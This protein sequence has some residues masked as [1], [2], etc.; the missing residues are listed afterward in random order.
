[1][2]AR[3]IARNLAIGIGL[4]ILLVAGL[5]WYGLSSETVAQRLIAKALTRAG[6]GITIGSVT[7]SIG[8]PLIVRDVS[9][10]QEAFAATIDSALLDWTPTGLIR[11]QIRI[12]RLHASGVHVTIPDS[13]PRDSAPKRPTLPMDVLLGD[14]LV[15]GLSVDAPN[16]IRIRGATARL[17]GRAEDYRF[18][19]AG[20][21]SLPR[22]EHVAARLR[23][24]GNLDHVELDSAGA[25][26][27]DGQLFA[28]GRVSWWPRTEWNLA[29]RGRNLEPGPLLEQP[30]R[31]PGAV[32]FVGVT[33]GH[34][35][36]IGPVGRLAIDT[37]GGAIRGQPLGGTAEV[38]FAGIAAEVPRADLRWGSARLTGRGAVADTVFADFDLVIGNLAT[39]LDDAGGSLRSS[40]TVRGTREAP[41][42]RA[43]FAGG[44]LKLGNAGAERA[45]GRAD[46][47]LSPRGRT[48]VRLDATGVTSGPIAFDSLTA[49]L[50]GRRDAHRLE[51][52]GSGPD[53]ALSVQADGGLRGSTWR[54]RLE[55]FIASTATYGEWALAAPTTVT[56]NAA[57]ATVA[58]SCILSPDHPGA[59]L[60]GSGAWLGGASWRAVAELERF[61]LA[62]LDA[63]VPDSV[64]GDSQ[65]LEGTLRASLAAES[66]GGRLEGR[67]LASAADAA[68]VYRRLAD[69]APR[70]IYFDSATALA[71]AGAGGATLDAGL[72]LLHDDS[73]A[74]A[75]LAADVSLPAFS[76]LGA[77]AGERLEGTVTG[78]MDSL[79][80]MTEFLPALDSLAGRASF[81]T[82]LAGTAGRP[83]FDGRLALDSIFV[84]L[85]RG[86]A[87]QGS[88][89]L[90]AA[91][92][93]VAPGQAAGRLTVVPRGVIYDYTLD[94]LPRR[95]FVDSGGIVA[96]V[97]GGGAGSWIEL[98][99]GISDSADSRIA[100]LSGR[101]DLPGYRA[102]GAPLGGEAMR[103]S[104][105]A[106][107]PDLAFARAVT[108]R[109][110]S[111]A[112]RVTL[113]A[114]GSGQVATPT[115]EAELRIEDFFARSETGT[116]T[117]GGL[118]GT[119]AAVVAPDS[120]L[121]GELKLVPSD[122]RFAYV[123]SGAFQ[124]ILL[125]TTALEVR[126]GADGIRG[127]LDLAIEDT[128][129]TTLGTFAGAFA[130]PGFR[131]I[132]RPI[133]P[134]PLEATLRAEVADLAF[135]EA[136]S[137][138]IDSLAGELDLDVAVGGT[139]G[140]PSWTGGLHLSN[141]AMRL[142]LLG[143]LYREIRF[144]A[145]GTDGGEVR[146]DGRAL[147]GEGEATL[148]GTTPLRPT[149]ERP[150][151]L[152]LNGRDFEA[153][154]TAQA[155]VVVT[156][157]LDMTL[158]GDTIELRGRVEVPRAHIQLTEIP[159][160]AVP[161]SDDVVFVGESLATPGTRPIRAEVEVVLG[162]SV[163]FSGFN[164]NADLSGALVLLESPLQPTRASGAVVIER[165]EYKAYGQDLTVT[166]G[167]VAFAGG[168]VDNPSLSIRASR[169]A[170][171]GTVAG[172]QI[173]G[174]LKTP[175]VTI[176]SE[177]AMS[178]N[179]ALHYI[180][181]GR[182][183]GEG[184]GADGSLLS[185]AASSL[186]L[187]G[188]NVLARSLGEGFGLDDARIESEEG[189][190]QASFV[191]GA[192][193]SP[194]LYVSYGIGLFDPIST[195][196]LRYLLSPKWTLQAE[197]GADTGADLLYRIERGR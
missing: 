160:F 103:L 84:W 63:F 32:D 172:L 147:S 189:F 49:V 76:R 92:Q 109:Y 102:F 11:R 162:D 73:S 42:V 106:E 97:G 98:A 140:D 75:T 89:E 28:Q 30:A 135:A 121:T 51:A 141:G 197:T 55:K 132:G 156:P 17:D 33:S 151:R 53:L 66:R 2:S 193:L 5:L 153:V 108:D 145:T 168:P 139:V 13:V 25:E 148:V 125:D 176:W 107:V 115:L 38:E 65:R 81:E 136:F 164:F 94:D 23:G 165:G 78:R 184:T 37:L 85:P 34:L 44:A 15:Q 181:M 142:P 10:R 40:G 62:L 45:R 24:T 59:R 31:W 14:V 48:D 169:T 101:L 131:R 122:V 144:D 64:F 69:T 74:M 196:R 175:Q 111:L 79:A 159:E 113:H 185:R 57:S 126:A 60:C 134:E 158:V 149:S 166:D 43:T 36:S 95:V 163:T 35:D 71:T 116:T 8:G 72:R 52:R 6:D 171:D 93:V 188:S 80:V 9:I 29:I 152:E 119:L 137:P 190:H 70:R 100:S 146:V 105:D 129:G 22:V 27:L 155:R 130:L 124:E 127:A 46:V 167:R 91:G 12:D 133:D 186:G 21:V 118:L 87:G 1:V 174:S 187:R 83:S 117:R 173:G 16:D 41:H 82:R 195:L 39:A 47:V 150:G 58:E 67:L 68:L 104:L 50:G 194:S 54:G 192:Y 90:T 114:E 7:G 77:L 3:R 178:Q 183:P 177:P 86:R 18:V 161:P 179:S 154:N 170:D 182:A 26:L 56:A 19:A 61:P 110:D 112:G 138:E 96:E 191:A 128:A 157:D 180:V 143:A 20:S 123:E 120:T 99:L 4:F 88:V